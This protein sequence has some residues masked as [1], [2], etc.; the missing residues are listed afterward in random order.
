MNL[1]RS[2]PAG[3]SPYVQEM[4]RS[5]AQVDARAGNTDRCNPWLALVT[6]GRLRAPTW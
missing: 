2:A 5:A 3:A 6:E 1:L 4:A